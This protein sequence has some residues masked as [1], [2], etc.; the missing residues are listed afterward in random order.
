MKTQRNYHLTFDVDYQ[1][2][3]E[4]I[5]PVILNFLRKMDVTA[6]FFITGRFALENEECVRQIAIAGHELGVHG[7]DHGFSNSGEDFHLNDEAI[8]IDN[9][10]RTKSLLESISGKKVTMN[11][12][13][14]LWV[15]DSL[16]SVLDKAQIQLDSSIP[17]G[18]FIGQIRKYK[19]SFYS[20]KKV[21]VSAGDC[22][23]IIEVPPTAL[24]LPLNTSFAR[25]F[26]SDIFVLFQRVLSYFRQQIVIYTHPAEFM[27]A[28]EVEYDQYELE[29]YKR[30][31]GPQLFEVLEKSINL[32]RS[33]GFE[34]IGME[35]AYIK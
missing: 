33:Q 23:S 3:T 24:I 31:T 27:C 26:G 29:R 35:R 34:V 4:K 15:N 20:T 13:P 14:N 19:Y 6:S 25:M 10:V 12:N 8:Q 18:R 17:A 9:I 2:G 7:W 21:I 28:D 22:R 11:R 32:A 30:N 5:I 1:P 16:W